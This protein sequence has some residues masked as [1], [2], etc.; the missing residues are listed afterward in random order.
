MKVKLTSLLLLISTCIF[1]QGIFPGNDTSLISGQQ[2]KVTPLDK[3]FQ[4]Y[5]YEGFYKDEKLKKIYECCDGIN[6]KFTACFTK[7]AWFEKP[8]YIGDFL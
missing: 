3:M 6:S 4:K 7:A 2:L 1:G 5:G 8:G